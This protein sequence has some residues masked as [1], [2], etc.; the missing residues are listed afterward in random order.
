MNQAMEKEH[1]DQNAPGAKDKN[2]QNEKKDSA[3]PNQNSG[4]SWQTHSPPDQQ[5]SASQNNEWQ[6]NHKDSPIPKTGQQGY[7]QNKESTRPDNESDAATEN[8]LDAD[9]DYRREEY[10]EENDLESTDQDYRDGENQSGE[11]QDDGDELR[12]G[13]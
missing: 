4:T 3:I 10:I 5:P 6:Q 12:R 13:K 7:D 11:D 8:E 1:K 9:K 2:N